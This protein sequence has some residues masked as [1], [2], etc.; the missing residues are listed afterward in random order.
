MK[1]QGEHGNDD[2]AAAESGKCAQQAG[3]KRSASDQERESNGRHPREIWQEEVGDVRAC[4]VR[5]SAAAHSALAHISP[6]LNA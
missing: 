1:E 6:Y 3:S 5:L 4:S 2:D